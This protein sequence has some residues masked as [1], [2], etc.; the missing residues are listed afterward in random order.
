MFSELLFNDASGVGTSAI[1]RFITR[2][3]TSLSV[4][5]SR[6]GQFIRSLNKPF[7]L[8]RTLLGCFR[9]GGKYY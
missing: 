6:E 4:C 8:E 1:I 3:D 5:Y 7:I 9:M 2:S